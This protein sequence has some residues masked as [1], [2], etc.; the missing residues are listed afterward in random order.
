MDL[1]W[2][3]LPCTTYAFW[4]ITSIHTVIQYD[5]QVCRISIKALNFNLCNFLTVIGSVMKPVPW[6]IKSE[7][8]FIKI[9]NWLYLIQHEN[10]FGISQTKSALFNYSKQTIQWSR[11]LVYLKLTGGLSGQVKQV[12]IIN[13]E[14]LVWH[15]P[16]ITSSQV[17]FRKLR[18][19][20]KTREFL[21]LR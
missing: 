2:S 9:S 3:L 11:P 12:L 13:E 18:L 14:L 4:L 16:I 6:P 1:T 7:I 5:L 8:Q 21:N 15:S 17:L 10:I 20:S 19:F